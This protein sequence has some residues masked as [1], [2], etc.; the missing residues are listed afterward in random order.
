MGTKG[1][2][3]EGLHDEEKKKK[4]PRPLPS[5]QNTEKRATGEVKLLIAVYESVH[6]NYLCKLSEVI[7]KHCSYSCPE[8]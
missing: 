5:S 2:L 3:G 4:A 1:D 8:K 6:G 7:W